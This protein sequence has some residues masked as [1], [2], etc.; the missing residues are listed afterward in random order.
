MTVYLVTN[1]CFAKLKKFILSAFEYRVTFTF[2]KSIWA[3]WTGQT[4][5]AVVINTVLSLDT[6]WVMFHV[7]RGHH[8]SDQPVTL[9]DMSG[10]DGFAGHGHANGSWSSCH[11]YL[12][13]LSCYGSCEGL[14]RLVLYLHLPMSAVLLQWSW[15]SVGSQSLHTI[16]KIC[17]LTI[18][19]LHIGLYFFF[20]SCWHSLW[21][22]ASLI[23]TASIP[24]ISFIPHGKNCIWPIFISCG[25]WQGQHL[26][27][28]LLQ[29]SALVKGKRRMAQEWYVCI[30][31]VLLI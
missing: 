16:L 13:E 19:H 21:Y 20:A 27:N 1:W 24:D 11:V 5:T 6:G 3:H 7:G 23:C 30:M 18:Y 14:T 9:M 29:A 4:L 15:V 28:K 25:H 2:W 10:G 31:F 17:H 26:G 12:C 22:Y 8:F